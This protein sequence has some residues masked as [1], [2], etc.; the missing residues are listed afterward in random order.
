MPERAVLPK[1]VQKPHPPMWVTVTSAGT[2]LDAAERGLG[3]L[4]VAAASFGEQERRT[5]AYHRRIQQSNPVGRVND[6]VATLNF[7]H[8]HEDLATG[9]QR[10]M[11]FLGMFGLLNSHL[12][13][14][15]EAFPTTAY[16]SLAG[17]VAPSGSKGGGNPGA[18][19]GVPEGVCIGC[20]PAR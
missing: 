15:R 8:C 19:Y 12:L 14:T 6:R 17:L 13:F 3:C 5:K 1:P 10:G 4:G 20:S 2:E 11:Q 18:Q 7:M 9:A 16:Q